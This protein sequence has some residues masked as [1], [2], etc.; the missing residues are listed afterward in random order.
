MNL[1]DR[2]TTA[3]LRGSVNENAARHQYIPLKPVM[4]TPD[5][6]TWDLVERIQELEAEKG[7]PWEAPAALAEALR[8]QL[9]ARQA[10]AK[11]IAQLEGQAQLRAAHLA[12]LEAEVAA[13]CKALQLLD[14]RMRQSNAVLLQAPGCELPGPCY[15]RNTD[16]LNEAKRAT[17]GAPQ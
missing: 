13:L 5:A 2:L 17:A 4:E 8:E 16:A 7:K 3:V 12:A 11:R 6:T 9:V 15:A 14:G 1:S 10:D